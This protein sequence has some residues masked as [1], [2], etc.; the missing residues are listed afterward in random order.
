MNSNSGYFN[1]K[2]PWV[3]KYRPKSHRDL[4]LNPDMMAQIEHWITCWDSQQMIF[5][6]PPGV[7]KTS[8]AFA[9]ARSIIGENF[10]DHTLCVNSA[11]KSGTENIE[12]VK[13]FCRVRNRDLPKIVIFDECDYLTKDCQKAIANLINQH[14]DKT[15]FILTCNDISA[16]NSN[17]QSCCQIFHYDVV[18]E[19]DCMAK[20]KSVCCGENLSYTN[21]GLRA[22]L[23]ISRG[24]L[25]MAINILQ[26]THLCYGK[27][28]EENV[29]LSCQRPDP[30]D[31]E[32]II[33]NCINCEIEELNSNLIS[34][35]SRGYYFLDLLTEIK[36]CV[37][38][39]EMEE[40]RRMFFMEKLSDLLVT[41]AD[42]GSAKTRLQLF[43]TLCSVTEYGQA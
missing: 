23:R 27:I 8:T 30:K 29:V 41:I 38:T 18:P 4:H 15:I 12:R 43:A 32:V 10:R 19:E 26:K 14:N 35:M 13:S 17:I 34:I 31:I 33:K 16:V 6:G 11:D 42:S 3:E 24:D 7:G 39:M 25:R 5:V 37:L 20:I 1:G 21:K 2:L 40:S 9:I 22:L 36:D 28:T